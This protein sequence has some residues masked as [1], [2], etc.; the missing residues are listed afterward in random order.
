MEVTQITQSLNSSCPVQVPRLQ[1]LII[2]MTGE[3]QGACQ[4]ND[5]MNE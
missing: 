5:L 2:F 1:F 3:D 4:R